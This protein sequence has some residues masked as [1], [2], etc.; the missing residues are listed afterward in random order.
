MSFGTMTIQSVEL[1]VLTSRMYPCSVQESDTQAGWRFFLY[2][3]P[4]P[5]ESSVDEDMKTVFMN[6]VNLYA[7]DE[8]IPL[9]DMPDFTELEF[10]LKEPYSPVSGETYFTLDP[11]EAL[12]VSDVALRFLEK[13]DACYHIS[14]TA[15]VHHFAKEPT[16]LLYDGWIEVTDGVQAGSGEQE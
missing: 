6:G 1:T 13:K 4:P 2:A 3:G 14:L 15:Q 7:D 8:P 11:G 9:P 16:P 5:E 10:T 12:D